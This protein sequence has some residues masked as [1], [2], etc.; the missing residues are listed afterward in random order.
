MKAVLF[1]GLGGFLGANLRYFVVDWAARRWGSA[2]PY[3]TLL[4]NLL[5]SFLI[6]LLMV[7]LAE[8]FSLA[9][10]WKQLLISGFLG[11]F[12]TFSSFTWELVEQVKNG[13][14]TQAVLY[15]VLSLVLGLLA[16][17]AGSALG[18]VLAGAGAASP[19]T[20]S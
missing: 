18:A 12:T 10:Q 2:L 3:G 20:A 19:E 4:V 16:V 14:G 8:Q 11:A 7:W 1:I 17:L 13:S 9:P 15:L 5:G 6:G